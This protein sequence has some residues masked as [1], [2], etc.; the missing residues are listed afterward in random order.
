MAKINLFLHIKRSYHLTSLKY[1]W[2]VQKLPKL[3]FSYLCDDRNLEEIEKNIK[4]RKGVG[5]IRLI[6]ELKHQLDTLSRA[7]SRYED[8]QRKFYNECRNIPNDTHQDVVD[9]ADEPRILKHIGQPKEFNFI[10]RDFHEITKRLN[11]LRTEQLG[12]LSGHRSYYLLG[13]L[14]EMERALVQYTLGNLMRKNFKVITVPD[15]L[16]RDIIEGCGL[17]TRGE[18]TQVGF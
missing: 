3:D 16:H 14:A 5:N 11:L 15:I 17:N 6:R 13:A 9:Y 8:I 10:P 2:N 12:Y 4:R 7:D 1:C 18:R